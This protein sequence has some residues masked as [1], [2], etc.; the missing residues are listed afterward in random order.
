VTASVQQVIYGL[1]GTAEASFTVTFPSLPLPGDSVILQVNAGTTTVATVSG[2]GATWSRVA[3]MVGNST[4]STVEVWLGTG[5]SGLTTTMLV[6]GAANF[7]QGAALAQEWPGLLVQRTAA[8]YTSPS[9]A[10]GT[11]ASTASINA[12]AGDLVVAT[13]S[14]QNGSVGGVK[15]GPPAGWTNAFWSQS[16]VSPQYTCTAY[17][18]PASP[19]AVSASFMPKTAGQLNT[20]IVPFTFAALPSGT[21]IDPDDADTV[22]SASLAAKPVAT[23]DLFGTPASPTVLQV[24]AINSVSSVTIPATQAGSV[25][26]IM[27]VNTYGDNQPWAVTAPANAGLL[28]TD[29]NNY[30]T[31]TFDIYEVT[32]P[33]GT[34]TVTINVP[35][36]YGFVV[37]VANCPNPVLDFISTSGLEV[38]PSYVTANGPRQLPAPELCFSF[39]VNDGTT[40]PNTPQGWTGYPV[41]GYD[42]LLCSQK[43]LAGTTPTYVPSFPGGNNGSIFQVYLFGIKPGPQL[44]QYVNGTA[45]QPSVTFPNVT[46]AGNGLIACVVDSSSTGTGDTAPPT[47]SGWQMVGGDMNNPGY[48]ATYYFVWPNHPGG[49]Q[50]QTWNLGLNGGTRSSVT[51]AEFSGMPPALAVDQYVEGPPTSNNQTYTFAGTAAPVGPNELILSGVN[52]GP[53]V[54]QATTSA[55]PNS[56]GTDNDNNFFAWGL[57][58]N[59]AISQTVNVNGSPSHSGFIVLRAAIESVT[60]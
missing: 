31:G 42:D 51:I 35:S 7:P 33:T 28:Y 38:V 8:Q 18:T 50:S 9:P 43:V 23:D 44:V 40:V 17:Q 45:N 56:L 55:T 49:I 27:G 1:D 20:L 12:V 48:G 25:L 3:Q 15:L 22:D 60:P 24:T 10:S 11:F 47:G 14:T 46:Q 21:M 53:A 58:G 36:I 13:V 16:G 26:L 2:L 41:D 34:T 32:P 6:T 57:S 4:I 59:A 29:S 30:I 39:L 19:G 37:E 5:C 54:T 52:S